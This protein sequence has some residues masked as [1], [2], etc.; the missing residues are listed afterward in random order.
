MTA[1]GSQIAPQAPAF[2]EDVAEALYA[3]LP[4]HIRA[5]DEAAGGA[6]RGL[7]GVAALGFAEVDAEL[8]RFQDA[9][10]VET[11]PAVALDAIAALVGTP[12][13][14]PMP[15]GATAS[16]RSFIA[17]MLRYRRGKGTARVTE[18]VAADVS[19][20]GTVAVEYYQ[21]LVKLAHLIDPRP[22]RLGLAPL[23]DGEILA[24]MG[25]AFDRAPRLAAVAGVTAA[26]PGYPAGRHALTAVGLHLNRLQTPSFPASPG[27]TVTAAAL[28]GV[29]PMRQ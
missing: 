1:V 2:V 9:L 26:R 16:L 15:E 19:G 25:S 8:D 6:V 18:A 3:L 28:A 12:T 7:V 13:L 22:E 27:D 4:A 11:A 23:I 17:N 10:F 14:Q 21:R 29:P 20:Q 24:R 5:T